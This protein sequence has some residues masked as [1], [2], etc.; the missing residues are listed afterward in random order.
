[1]LLGL[2]NYKDKCIFFQ[3]HNVSY[4]VLP[5]GPR[6]T[7]RSDTGLSASDGDRLLDRAIRMLQRLNDR[8]TALNALD[9]QQLRRLETLEYK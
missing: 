5:S 4:L 7:D 2:Q 6:N 9:E 3:I 8:L 1:V